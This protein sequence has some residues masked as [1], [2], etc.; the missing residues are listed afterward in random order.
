MRDGAAGITMGA[1]NIR[2]PQARENSCESKM[3]VLPNLVIC[4]HGADPVRNSSG[5]PYLPILS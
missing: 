4:S 3:F 5:D 2:I 1:G